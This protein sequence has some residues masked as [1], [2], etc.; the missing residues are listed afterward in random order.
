MRKPIAEW[1][2]RRT[3]SDEQNE[4]IESVPVTT[5]TET[6][7]ETIAPVTETTEPVTETADATT[8]TVQEPTTDVSESTLLGHDILGNEIHSTNFV[9]PVEPVNAA[10]VETINS[11]AAEE[12]SEGGLLYDL[13]Q[14]LLALEQRIDAFEQK[15][16]NYAGKADGEPHPLDHPDNSWLRDLLGEFG[17]RPKQ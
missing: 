16:A 3:M 14:R 15:A 4:T 9:K 17:I 5:E 11:G 7:T 10:P 13:K 12:P 6:G 8:E 1:W 2:K